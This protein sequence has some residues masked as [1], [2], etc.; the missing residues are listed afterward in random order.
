[1]LRIGVGN[2]GK[3]KICCECPIN[4]IKREQR[5]DKKK[6]ADVLPKCWT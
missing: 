6:G 3:S 1:M 5:K 2:K 4:E